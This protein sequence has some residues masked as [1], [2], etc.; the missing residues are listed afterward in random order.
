MKTINFFSILG[1]ISGCRLRDSSLEKLKQVVA[2]EWQCAA[3]KTM[4][5]SGVYINANVISSK[6][7]N[8]LKTC[9]IGGDNSVCITGTCDPSINPNDYK[10]A[11]R[12]I[13]QQVVSS[14]GIDT[15]NFYFSE[16]ELEKI[17]I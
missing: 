3:K 1:A 5:K 15:A 6:I 14:L 2:K 10:V 8:N 11:V 4:N 9:P 7:A 16:I 12:E 17:E 13:L